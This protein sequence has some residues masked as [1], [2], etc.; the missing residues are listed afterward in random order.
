MSIKYDVLLTVSACPEAYEVYLI[1]PQYKTLV[2]DL[3]LRHGRFTVQTTTNDIIHTTYPEGDGIFHNEERTPHLV[4]AI[5]KLHSHLFGND[6][7]FSVNI[8]RCRE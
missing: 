5:I 7:L 3:R 2:A 8:D 4:Q 6:K 1:T